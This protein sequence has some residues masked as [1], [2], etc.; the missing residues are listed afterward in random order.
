[1][2][3]DEKLEILLERFFN[4]FNSINTKTL[5]MLGETVKLFDGISPSEAHI[6]AQKLKYGTDLDDLLRELSKAS[7]KSIQDVQI[8]LD[9]VAEENVAFSEV[10]YKAKKKKYVPY[11]N[12]IQLKRYVKGIANETNSLFKNIAKSKNIG[13]TFK[14]AKGKV[15]FKPLAEVYNDLIDEAVY[16]VSTGTTDFYSAMR[17]T[18]KRLADSG[19]KV[20][21]DKVGYESGYNRRI[22]SSVRMNVLSAVRQININVQK[23]VG[24]EFSADGVEVSAHSPCAE[25]HLFINGRQ[26]SNKQ[27]ERINNSLVRPVGELN[28]RHYVFSIVLGVNKPNYTDE[29]LNQ[30]EQESLKKIEYEGKKYTK[31]EA[32]QVQRRLETMVRKQKDRQII[33]KASGDKKEIL[34]AQQKITQLTHKY[35]D[36]S[37]K[38]GL[39]TYKERLTISGYKRTRVK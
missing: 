36:F 29:E 7:G 26:F 3:D 30:M 23:Q 13:F 17:N 14:N 8:M 10:Y 31:Y 28:C 39:K 20:H 16:N 35:N 24:R 4:R 9:K 33:A 38:V 15:I 5:Q 37:K 2:S 6:L 1:M 27:F 25:D 11:K 22:D 19:V 34:N 12:N 21:E 32:T 18:L